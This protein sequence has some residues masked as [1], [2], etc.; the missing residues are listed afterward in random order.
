MQGLNSDPPDQYGTMTEHSG[1]YGFR[2]T[3]TSDHGSP[4]GS[5]VDDPGNSVYPYPHK[6]DVELDGMTYHLLVSLL[7]CIHF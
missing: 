6:M 3:G 5:D 1:S 7:Q 2:Q 4:S